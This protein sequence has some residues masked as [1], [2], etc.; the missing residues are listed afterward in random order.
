M[1]KVVNLFYITCPWLLQ[2]VRE[3]FDIVAMV[4]LDCIFVEKGRMN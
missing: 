1:I 3:S 2:N 4:S